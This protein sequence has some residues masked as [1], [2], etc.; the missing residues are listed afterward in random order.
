MIRLNAEILGV[1][2]TADIDIFTERAK[3][4]DIMPGSLISNQGQLCV[5]QSVS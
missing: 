5:S 4:A 2:L 3:V 1:I